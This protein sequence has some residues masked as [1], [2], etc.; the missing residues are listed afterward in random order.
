MLL[1]FSH[2]QID[3][4]GSSELEASIFDIETLL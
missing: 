4:V 3:V 1:K 2:I